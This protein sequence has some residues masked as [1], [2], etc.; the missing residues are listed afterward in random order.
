MIYLCIVKKEF[1][2]WLMDIAKYIATAVILTSVFGGIK[3][4]WV[5]YVGG[6]S[7]ISVTLIGGLW[8][9]RD[10]KKGEK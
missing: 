8:L 2:K 3:E 1:G 6:M 5:I 7:A 9:L 10:K 4:T